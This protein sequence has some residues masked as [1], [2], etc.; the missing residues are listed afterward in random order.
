MRRRE[1]DLSVISAKIGTHVG[2][3]ATDKI[4]HLSDLSKISF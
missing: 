3:D 2:E 4:Y 1:L